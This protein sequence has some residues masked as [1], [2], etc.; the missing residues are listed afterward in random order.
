[1]L[2]KILGALLLMLFSYVFYKIL[3]NRYRTHWKSWVGVGWIIEYNSDTRKITIPT[4]LLNSPAGRAKIK[5]GSVLLSRNGKKLLF[6]T[7]EDFQAW[8]T[9]WGAPVAGDEV[10]YCLLEPAGKDK[11]NERTV[12]LKYERLRGQIPYYAPLPTSEQ[13]HQDWRRLMPNFKAVYPT[14]RCP[15]TG[16]I[17]HRVRIIPVGDI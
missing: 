3:T 2:L 5:R 17:Y 14:F 12:T 16:V 11:W 15:R 7:K 10:T 6:E 8:V 1:M 4:Y 9:S 13:M